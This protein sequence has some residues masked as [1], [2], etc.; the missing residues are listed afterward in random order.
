ME[1]AHA[2]SKSSERG[3]RTWRRAWI[4][5]RQQPINR[6]IREPIDDL[7]QRHK[8]QARA[9]KTGV[10]ETWLSSNNAPFDSSDTEHKFAFKDGGT[11]ACECISSRDGL[12]RQFEY[13]QPELL[14]SGLAEGG[15]RR[16][17][18][19]SNI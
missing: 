14:Q 18:G 7:R 10:V 6:G 5:H 16:C 17:Q 2:S 13:R 3:W 8:Q 4:K 15:G 9:D 11:V 1:R 19:G 12:A